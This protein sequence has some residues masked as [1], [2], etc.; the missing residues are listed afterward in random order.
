[1]IFNLRGLPSVA[2]RLAANAAFSGSIE[3]IAK[4][5]D[6][7]FELAAF[8]RRNNYLAKHQLFIMLTKIKNGQISHSQHLLFLYLNANC[9]GDL[10]GSITSPGGLV[11]LM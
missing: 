3:G 8:G 5:S 4:L 11:G 10:K 1:M 7:L 6:P 2:P 9:S